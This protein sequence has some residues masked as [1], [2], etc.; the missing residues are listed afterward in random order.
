M[1]CW[2]SFVFAVFWFFAAISSSRCQCLE[3]I[4]SKSKSKHSCWAGWNNSVMWSVLFHFCLVLPS[5]VITSE[6]RLPIKIS[7]CFPFAFLAS[8]FSRSFKQSLINHPWCHGG[9]VFHVLFCVPEVLCPQGQPC[10]W[11]SLWCAGERAPSDSSSEA[12]G[13]SGVS[14]LAVFLRKVVAL[15]ALSVFLAVQLWFHSVLA[16]LPSNQM[17]CEYL[18]LLWPWGDDYEPLACACAVS[19][20]WGRKSIR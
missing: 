2:V 14:S 17:W 19:D 7:L 10:R 6:Q 5:F 16:R 3:I 9:C 1:W 4:S 18:L 12:A 11:F 8:A 15:L 13:C 20:I